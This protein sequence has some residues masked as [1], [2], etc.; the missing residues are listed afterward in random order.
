MYS[1]SEF[2][3]DSLTRR[4]YKPFSLSSIAIDSEFITASP[5]LNVRSKSRISPVSVLR[6]IKLFSSSSSLIIN[7]L[8]FSP[9]SNFQSPLSVIVW[10]FEIHEEVDKLLMLIPVT[11]SE[12]R[13][14]PN[15]ISKGWIEFVLMV[16]SEI[17]SPF[18]SI[19]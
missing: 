19:E 8:L 10:E 9:F 5:S 16:W 4:L 14:W 6:V 11:L 13:F 17:S 2:S 7:K 12:L 3:P 1:V 15:S 18:E